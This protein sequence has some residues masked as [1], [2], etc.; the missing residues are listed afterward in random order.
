[1]RKLFILLFSA[2]LLF[3][4]V[5]KAAVLAQNLNQT[6]NPKYRGIVIEAQNQSGEPGATY[7]K[8]QIKTNAGETVQVINDPNIT[9]KNIEYKK[10]DRVILQKVETANNT[11][12]TYII[13][14]YQRTG[15]I[16]I[17]FAGFVILAILVGRKRSLYSL[18]GMAFSF[19]VIF[20]FLLPQISSGKNP[21]LITLAAVLIITPVTF[22]LSHGFNK[23]THIALFSTFITLLGT[24]L[25]T[26]MSIKLAHL[27]G[28]ASDEAMFLQIANS[29][30]N[31]RGILLSGIIIGFLG[32]LDDVTVAQAGIVL[33]LKN[34]RKLYPQVKLYKDAMKLG[35]D[36]ISSM[37][38]TLVLVYSGASMP[39]LLLFINNPQPF[40]YVLNAE[41]IA[42]EIIRTL[43]GSIGLIVAVPLTTFVAVYFTE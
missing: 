18:L 23:K 26:G 40:G 15:F 7:Q 20:R 10:G 43:V 24:I 2:T 14:D 25:L 21:L 1:M 28:Y 34:S 22:Y 29:S 12:S 30:I 13:T 16:T 38:N 39:L 8:L 6:Q 37:I 5:P 19:F 36:H 31:M 35:K 4:L 42:D 41:L 32:V 27:T 9:G 17:L 3:L 11:E 33:Q